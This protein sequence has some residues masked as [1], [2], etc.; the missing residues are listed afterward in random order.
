[1]GY[2]IGYDE[3]YK[4]VFCVKTYELDDVSS[5]GWKCPVCDEYIR[6]AAPELCSG[7]IKVRKKAGIN[8]IYS[9]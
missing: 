9:D 6:I 3:R 7:H 5:S 8:R 2:S 1:M 4:C